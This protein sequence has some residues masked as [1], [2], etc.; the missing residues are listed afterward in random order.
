M[1]SMKSTL[2]QGLITVFKK[3]FLLNSSNKWSAFVTQELLNNFDTVKVSFGNLYFLTSNPLLLWRARTLLTKEPETISWINSFHEDDILFDIGANVGMFSVYAGA[4]GIKTYSFEPESSNYYL[5][6]RNILRNNLSS[7]VL[8]FNIALSDYENFSTLALSSDTPGAAHTSFMGSSGSDE[9]SGSIF[10]QGC[11][12]TTLDALVGM[13]KFVVPNHIK[14]DVDGLE[15]RIIYGARELLRNPSLKS[16]LVEIDKN[17]ASDNEI[18]EIMR[19]N[20]FVEKAFE[21]NVSVGSGVENMFF[22]RSNG[23]ISEK[24]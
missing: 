5:L 21:N 20:G 2:I 11:F 16:I 6:N 17:K 14:I 8:A 24:I 3:I 23:Q 15:Q 12:G 9:S 22:F 10:N 7:K 4:R 13:Y 19:S 18:V 1:V